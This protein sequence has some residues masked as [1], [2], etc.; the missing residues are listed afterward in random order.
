MKTQSMRQKGKSYE[1]KRDRIGRNR[2]DRN[3]EKRV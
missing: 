1:N 2:E 3:E